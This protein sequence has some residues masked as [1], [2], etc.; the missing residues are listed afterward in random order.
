MRDREPLVKNAA[1]RK[2]V[3]F[4]RRKEQQR[5]DEFLAVVR[6]VMNQADGRRLMWEILGRAGLDDTVFDHSGS[7]MYFREGRRN[8]GLEL[9]AAL[10]RADE[11]L[12]ELMEHDMRAKQRAEA[13]EIAAM[14]TAR[15][16]TGD[17]TP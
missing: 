16:D 8:F 4:A 12:F 15:A 10:L 5:E 2:Q 6:A 17:D 9:K 13:A 7:I 3:A 1:D 11:D 14:H